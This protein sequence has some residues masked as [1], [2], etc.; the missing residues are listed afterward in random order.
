MRA[1]RLTPVP[2]VF[3]F[4]FM[5]SVGPWIRGSHLLQNVPVSAA[6]VFADF[7]V[8]FV[9]AEPPAPHQTLLSTK[10]HVRLPYRPF[11]ALFQ[12]ARLLM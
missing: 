3:S 12:C 10:M 2:T 11:A 6:G 8:M 7:L 1:K 5:S 4:M 9:G